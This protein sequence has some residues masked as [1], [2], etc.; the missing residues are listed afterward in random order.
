LKSGYIDTIS[1]LFFYFLKSYQH[2]TN[3][4]LEVVLCLPHKSIFVKK[5]LYFICK[6]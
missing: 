6:K 1:V 2:N 5:K 3:S 4:L